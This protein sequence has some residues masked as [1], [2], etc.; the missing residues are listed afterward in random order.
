MNPYP[1]ST[2]Q[3]L[4]HIALGEDS[5]RQF[6]RTVQQADTLAAGLVAFANSG[7]GSLLIGVGDDGSICGLD[8]EQVRH[9]N[10]LLSSTAS[11]HVCPPIQLVTHN[12]ATPQGL[13]VHVH[14]PDGLS[15][16]YLDRLGR[17]WVKQGAGKRH[18]TTREEMLRM[19]QRA[20]LVYVDAMPVS[21][22]TATIWSAPPS[23]SWCLP[24]ASRSSTPATC[25][26]G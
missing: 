6:R 9:I 18:I 11:Q 24:T 21:G 15:K 12:L 16:P 22:S 2:A 25:P 5:T 20:G 13:V 17:I 23:A 10:Q 14:I 7:G 26:T 8:G 1:L 4:E 3:L 19:F